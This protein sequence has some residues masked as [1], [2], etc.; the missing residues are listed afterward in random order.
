MSPDQRRA[1]EWDC[2]RLIH[3]YAHLNDGGRWDELAS[4]YVAEA[5]MARP[6]APDDLV[7]GRDAILASLKARPP[8]LGVH[9]CT[10]VI[11]DVESLTKARADS[12]ILLF[13]AADQSSPPAASAPLVGAFQDTLCHTP[14]GWRFVERRGRLLFRP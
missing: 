10:N 14:E 12:R 2:T 4:L 3:L 5:S 11:V 1:I 7:V 6:S 8:R 13:L 9:L